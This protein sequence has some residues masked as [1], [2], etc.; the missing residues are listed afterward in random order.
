MSRRHLP[1]TASQRAAGLL[2]LVRWPN[3]LLLMLCQG[4][5]RGWLIGPPA[6]L[7]EVAFLHL[8]AATVCIAAAGYIINDYYDVKIDLINR[9]GRVIVGRYL[10]RR[11]ALVL[12]AVLNATGLL[13][14]LRLGY[15]V[16]IINTLAVFLLW[17]YSNYLKRQPFWGNLTISLLTALSLGVLSVYYHQHLSEIR[18]YALFAFSL[19]L[20]REIIK[21]M[22]DVRGD[23]SFGCLTIP[24]LWGIRNTKKLLYGLVVL[25]GLMLL[26]LALPLQ[27]TVL[28]A[29]FG[30]LLLPVGYLVYRL[31]Y[32]DTRQDFA[33]LS[34]FCKGLMLAGLLT[35]LVV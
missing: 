6:G 33:F 4:L 7:L 18:M 2:R 25:F 22:E 16:L 32:A 8:V 15:R 1:L 11:Q 28:S 27:N 13:L 5:V 23:G 17:W 35:M 19:S 31:Y 9:P 10:S 34:Q 14:T 21:D 3:L 29:L 26:M 30:L 24:I 20:I 12:Y